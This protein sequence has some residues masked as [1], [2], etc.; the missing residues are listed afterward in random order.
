MAM[1]S[2]ALYLNL[3]LW[4]VKPTDMTQFCNK[5]IIKNWC[6]SNLLVNQISFVFFCRR[7]W[8]GL[9]LT[10]IFQTVKKNLSTEGYFVFVKS[11]LFAIDRLIA[12]P[13]AQGDQRVLYNLCLEF[14]AWGKNFQ[15]FT[16]KYAILSVCKPQKSLVY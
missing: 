8:N 11:L 9:L 5:I 14:V 2:D 13:K 3:P 1:H 4:V 15:G 16:Y 6:P 10:S 12:V 7:D